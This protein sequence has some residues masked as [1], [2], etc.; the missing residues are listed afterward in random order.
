MATKKWLIEN[1]ERLKELKHNYYLNRKDKI[2]EYNHN[3]KKIIYE[4]YGNKCACCGE[5]EFKFL[6][7]DHINNDG[8]HN[9][10]RKLG[11]YKNSWDWYKY[12]I[13]NNFP[14]NLQ[15]L[16][17]NCNFGKRMNDGICPH[18][19]GGITNMKIRR[20]MT[21]KEVDNGFT[22]S[23]TIYKCENDGTT[24]N[25]IIKELIV[26]SLPKLLKAVRAFY[27]SE[28]VEEA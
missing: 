26:D 24:V 25:S 20:T 12:I 9:K 14:D 27:E 8:H 10:K 2:R 13:K 28:I 16:C 23:N 11:K 3:L 4:H 22:L 15:L 1:K 17:M 19:I 6:S 18:I 5:I 7:I 21:I